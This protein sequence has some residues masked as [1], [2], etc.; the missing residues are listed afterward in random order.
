MTCTIRAELC[1]ACSRKWWFTD[2]DL[3]P[4]GET[5]TMFHIV[6]SCPLTKLNGGLS[7]LHSADENAVS[8]L[9]NIMVHDTHTKRRSSLE[10]ERIIVFWWK[11]NL[12][13]LLIQPTWYKKLSCSRET[14]RCFVSLNISLSYSRSPFHSLDMVFYSHFIVILAFPCII[15]FRDKAGHWSKI[16]IFHSHCVRRHC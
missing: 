12:L 4:C 14:A 3:C 6:E 5:Q 15:H 2:T 16:V 8:W 13:K 11:R 10:L 7:R 1:G 9:T